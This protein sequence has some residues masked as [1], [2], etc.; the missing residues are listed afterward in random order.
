[1]ELLELLLVFAG[2]FLI[3][4]FEIFYLRWLKEVK[5]VS[6]IRIGRIAALWVTGL[7]ALSPNQSSLP[8]FVWVELFFLTF[9]IVWAIN[10]HTAGSAFHGF[11]M[12]LW[13]LVCAAIVFY[14]LYLVC[15][16][17]DR[18]KKAPH[19]RDGRNK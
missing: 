10:S 16:F 3:L 11:F 15:S 8:T 13:Q 2:I 6:P 7:M 9:L 12:T 18:P 5:K 17:F 14:L 4:A 1:M 19:E